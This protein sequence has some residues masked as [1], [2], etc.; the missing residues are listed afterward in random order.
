MQGSIEQNKGSTINIINVERFAGL[1][2][3]SFQEYNKGF[4]MN[5]YYIYELY[6]MVLFKY[7]KCKAH[8]P[9]W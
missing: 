6:V 5:F 9:F 1:K 8:T 7:F 2:I 3:C 4:S